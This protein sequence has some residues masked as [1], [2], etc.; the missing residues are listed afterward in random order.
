MLTIIHH[1][2]CLNTGYLCFEGA[3]LTF[4]LPARRQLR[5]VGITVQNGG[6][7]DLQSYDGDVTDQWQIEVSLSRTLLSVRVCM[8]ILN[9]KEQIKL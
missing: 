4:E 9:S 1:V 7:L 5:F 6:I 2:S 8:V 3:T